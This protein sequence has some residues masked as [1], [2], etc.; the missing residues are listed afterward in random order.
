[1]LNPSSIDNYFL[2]HSSAN[3]SLNESTSF[4][5]LIDNHDDIFSIIEQAG[6]TF[7]ALTGSSSVDLLGSTS[8]YHSYEQSPFNHRLKRSSLLDPSAAEFHMETELGSISNNQSTKRSSSQ[9]DQQNRRTSRSQNNT[10][11][12]IPTSYEYKFGGYGR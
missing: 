11:Q 10:T 3:T 8:G 9:N 4:E 2:R 1:M 7:D 5:P 12:R 6:I